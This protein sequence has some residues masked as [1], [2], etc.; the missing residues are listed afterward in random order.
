[1]SL[2]SSPETH[3]ATL[4]LSLTLPKQAS[5]SIPCLKQ[6]IHSSSFHNFTKDE[7]NSLFGLL[8]NGQTLQNLK[9]EFSFRTDV[10]LNDIRPIL[11]ITQFPDQQ[12]LDIAAFFVLRGI[13]TWLT[14][15]IESFQVSS[16]VKILELINHV[17]NSSHAE[18]LKLAF[19]YV[20]DTSVKKIKES[21]LA[22]VLRPIDLFLSKANG[23][24]TQLTDV[25]VYLISGI[26]SQVTTFSDNDADLM[27]KTA[28]LICMFMQQ[29]NFDNLKEPILSSLSPFLKKFDVK[30]FSFLSQIIQIFPFSDIRL[31]IEPIPNA[32]IE[33][34]EKD[35]TYFPVPDTSSLPEPLVLE[36]NSY[37]SFPFIVMDTFQNGAKLS[38]A[39]YKIEDNSYETFSSE[40]MQLLHKIY[41]IGKS[42][43][44]QSF[45]ASNFIKIINANSDNEKL[46]DII[47]IALMICRDI[48]LEK[49]ILKSKLFDP[50]VTLFDFNEQFNSYYRVRLIVFKLLQKISPFFPDYI[51]S[52]YNMPL[53]TAEVF[54][55]LS[56]DVKIVAN[57][58]TRNDPVVSII[59]K[60]AG[61]Y[62]SANKDSTEHIKEIEYARISIIKFSLNLLRS[63]ENAQNLLSNILFSQMLFSYLYEKELRPLVI[64]A[65]ETAC[66]S[67]ELDLSVC[68]SDFFYNLFENVSDPL[69]KQE[70][71][72]SANN[73]ILSNSDYRKYFVNSVAPLMSDLKQLEKDD[74]SKQFL[75]DIVQFVSNT[76]DDFHILNANNILETIQRVEGD[77]PSEAIYNA[78][79]SFICGETLTEIQPT[80]EIK[81]PN[82]LTIFVLSF[83]KSSRF[84]SILKLLKDLCA[85]SRDNATACQIG[86]LDLLMI[87]IV[88]EERASAE[89]DIIAP[90]MSL[91]VHIASVS[92][93]PESIRK[94]FSVF[95]PIEPNV[96][97]YHQASFFAALAELVSVEEF[98]PRSYIPLKENSQLIS[99]NG[100]YGRQLSAGFTISL[101]IY[102]DKSSHSSP[103][104]FSIADA[105]RQ[106]YELYIKSNHLQLKI[107]GNMEKD[108]SLGKIHYYKWVNVSLTFINENNSLHLISCIDGVVLPPLDS[109]WVD[110]DKGLLSVFFGGMSK[111]SHSFHQLDKSALG[112][113]GIFPVQKANTLI[114]FSRNSL[115]D[116]PDISNRII[117]VDMK[118]TDHIFEIETTGIKGIS[119]KVVGPTL[120]IPL[121]FSQIL[122]ENCSMT[123]IL[124]LLNQLDYI[125]QDKNQQ[126][127]TISIIITLLTS[128][129][130]T[131][132][133]SQVV[134]YEARGLRI[135]VYLLCH[136][137]E[138]HLDYSLYESFLHLYEVVEYE[139]LK[140][141]ILEKILLNLEIW[142]LASGLSQCQISRYW[143]RT[144]F[145]NN[146]DSIKKY[147]SFQRILLLIRVYY[148]YTPVEKNIAWTK[149]ANDIPIS[150]VRQNFLQILHS[151]ATNH[152]SP[153]DFSAL[154]GHCISCKDPMQVSDLLSFLQLLAVSPESPIQGVQ[155]VWYQLTSLHDLIKSNDEIITLS[156][157]NVFMALHYLGLISTPKVDRHVSIIMNILPESIYTHSFFVKILP[158]GMKYHSF[159]PLIF[160][161]AMKLGDKEVNIL[162]ENLQPNKAFS[163]TK[164]WIL[165]PFLASLKYEN[166]SE[167]SQFILK[168][169]A[170]CTEDKWDE[171]FAQLDL[172]E[173]ALQIDASEAKSSFLFDV[174]E[175]ISTTQSLF[176]FE[177]L[178]TFLDVA[179]FHLF[180]REQG[181]LNKSLSHLYYQSPFA[182]DLEIKDNLPT[183]IE[184]VDRNMLFE[185]IK[186][187][188]TEPRK[189]VFGLHLDE[190]GHWIDR[191]L[192]KQVIHLAMMTKS[193][194]FH[195]TA[196]LIAGFLYHETPQESRELVDT[197]LKRKILDQ[198][199]ADFLQRIIGQPKKKSNGDTCFEIFIKEKSDHINNMAEYVSELLGRLQRFDTKCENEEQEITEKKDNG[200]RQQNAQAVFTEVCLE[201][202]QRGLYSK[203]W[204]ILWRMMTF[205]RFSFHTLKDDKNY[206][207][208]RDN[209]LS[210]FNC[211]T[212]WKFKS[213]DEED[214]EKQFS[215]NT[216]ALTLQQRKLQANFRAETLPV[217]RKQV[218]NDIDFQDI[219]DDM[220]EIPAHIVKIGKESSLC[221]FTVDG[222]QL[223]LNFKKN[224]KD[225]PSSEITEITSLELYHYPTAIEITTNDHKTHLLNFKSHNSSSILK[226]LSSLI[227]FKNVPIQTQPSNVYFKEL[228]HTN[229]WLKGDLSNFAYLMLVNKYGGRTFNNESIY[230]VLPWV[231]TNYSSESLDLSD[232]SNFR[233]FSKPMKP[234]APFSSCNGI[235]CFLKKC[236]PFASIEANKDGITYSEFTSI[237]DTFSSHDGRELTP[238]FYYSPEFFKDIQLPPWA[239]TP[240]EYVYKNRKALESRYVTEHINE[241]IDLLFG[242]NQK[243][244]ELD[245]KYFESI[246]DSNT[247]KSTGL[248]HEIETFKKAN[249]QVPHQLFKEFHPRRLYK[250]FTPDVVC[251][252][253]FNSDGNHKPKYAVLESRSE[254]IFNFTCVAENGTIYNIR[255]DAEKQQYSIRDTYSSIDA[256]ALALYAN[257]IIGVNS[258]GVLKIACDS[259]DALE[260]KGHIGK[261]NCI[262]SSSP[263][264]A[265]GCADSSIALYRS[266]EFIKT[267]P[268]F[269]SEVTCCDVLASFGLIVAG[270]LDCNLFFMSATD[271]MPKSCANTNGAVPK[272]VMITKKWG[273][274]VMYGEIGPRQNVIDI[275]TIHG[276][277]I[278][279]TETSLTITAWT[280]FSTR[281][282]FDYIV[283]ADSTGKL[284]LFEAF[285]GKIGDSFYDSQSHISHLVFSSE[286]A[287]AFAFSPNGDIFMAPCNVPT[288]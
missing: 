216:T 170:N 39:N 231:L 41:S 97:S 35:K 168:F 49:V 76:S 227:E 2:F 67:S 13:I 237:P 208:T 236:E 258:E 249:G 122:V 262:A 75:L 229:K 28:K 242:V 239:S 16:L 203:E 150:D 104:F 248:R 234:S 120:K 158:L 222:S 171:D 151:F 186:E 254:K 202:H 66:K 121:T 65:V 268:T 129:L 255:I 238:E 263:F 149:R 213:M 200:L 94:F 244:M 117:Y 256:C 63:K 1:M 38:D 139:Q 45:F 276:D 32:I 283:A 278:R 123:T 90:A 99:I 77:E 142:V 195:N 71:I 247:L 141:E 113:F 217:I 250:E 232:A 48:E 6:L 286:A 143:S 70:M 163:E 211:P 56:K 282:D 165:M 270:T 50:K 10:I 81:H 25:M 24:P 277:L 17:L 287:V 173:H 3:P 167:F 26:A 281:A 166:K 189:Y 275:Y 137:H 14:Q 30:A 252:H 138:K 214:E 209:T 126:T 101:W 174:C 95:S 19:V 37:Q 251:A 93:T 257:H 61:L 177:L 114:E 215:M 127:K 181:S 57:V 285:Y 205:D 199:F 34:I 44:V 266:N 155:D 52:I 103:K 235:L 33:Y 224:R 43:D 245:P 206:V 210:E 187:C 193:Q 261:G 130:V 279:R 20:L 87:D 219:K 253:C 241:W 15:P 115:R 185:K 23:V 36:F 128:I 221:R 198:P 58:I 201:A 91:Y 124:T 190:N 9:N 54:Q 197:I 83:R 269:S 240:I 46:F 225:F 188:K 180:Y 64:S 119:A 175:R 68:F 153:A 179:I 98:K 196:A 100:L 40:I 159:M 154:L 178:H 82:I 267:I 51:E 243:N 184:D 162:K 272:L 132:P 62:Q 259:G 92:S 47:I 27:D 74:F 260:I 288:S 148:W 280:S 4:I 160:Y 109:E 273:F 212:Q 116:V 80:F 11:Q 18:I 125:L 230:P 102:T 131:Q 204:R 31:I 8:S 96:V 218:E 69:F 22:D 226:A 191:E 133:Q 55:L 84:V 105:N 107:N 60:V 161:I 135:L 157:I 12:S 144:L 246:W 140:F 118:V 223:V 182:E 284:Y 59:G 79:L 147:L 152:F 112:P 274:V 176:Q 29:R 134:F 207:I 220:V 172:I 169:L 164:H 72:K 53:I 88:L 265:I 228:G 111:D 110:F 73:I 106:G 136:T 145:P 5:S 108:L 156:V 264:V 194:T 78:L 42:P 7:L 89:S 233:D 192:G 271:G 86:K 21:F 146:W 183:H 85:A